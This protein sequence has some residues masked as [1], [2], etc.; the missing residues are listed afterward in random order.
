[1]GHYL[2]AS[3]DKLF[4]GKTGAFAS[5]LKLLVSNLVIAPIQNA[6]YLA[7]MAY[8]AGADARGIVQTLQTRLFGV[9]KMTWIVFPS[10]QIVAFKV[11]LAFDFPTAVS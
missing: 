11:D 6:V 9:M 2:Y 4:A 5:I 10:V 8:I 7:A 3:L 1:M